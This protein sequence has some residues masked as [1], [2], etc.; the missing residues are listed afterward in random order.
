MMRKR[1]LLARKLL[2]PKDSVLIVTIDEKEYNHLGCL[3][4][5]LFPNA[6]IQMIS[7]VVAQKGVAR[8]NSFYRVNEYLYIIQFG[9]SKVSPLPLSEEWQLGKVIVLLQRV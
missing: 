3:L 2:N 9:T 6:N 1:L 4:E 5:D 7:S 8:N